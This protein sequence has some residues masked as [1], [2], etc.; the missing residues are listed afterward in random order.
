MIR[1]CKIFERHQVG[2]MIA[3]VNI[4]NFMFNNKLGTHCTPVECAPGESCPEVN[5]CRIQGDSFL[6]QIEDHILRSGNESEVRRNLRR[7]EIKYLPELVVT[8]ELIAEMNELSIM[9]DYSTERINEILS[10]GTEI[11]QVPIPEGMSIADAVE[12]PALLG[13]Q[14]GG[15]TKNKDKNTNTYFKKYIKYKQKYLELLKKL[16]K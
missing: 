16:N 3:H 13:I 4:S 15:I 8:D 2:I 12:D 14:I 10:D 9:L 7:Y 6:R 1:V 5:A 11:Q